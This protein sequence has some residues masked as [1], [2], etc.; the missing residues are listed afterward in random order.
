MHRRNGCP[1]VTNERGSE[2]REGLRAV[3]MRAIVT[4]AGPLSCEMGA[5]R[6]AMDS[7]GKQ[8]SHKY[9]V[10]M[11]QSYEKA[12]NVVQEDEER[13]KQDMERKR[14]AQY[15][16]RSGVFIPARYRQQVTVRFTIERDGQK[17]EREISGLHTFDIGDRASREL[18]GGESGAALLDRET[19]SVLL[20]F[21]PDQ[22]Q[23]PL[24]RKTTKMN[25]N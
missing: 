23:N 11:A 21:E 17:E 1:S 10:Y 25:G 13:A 22:W 16:E 24:L 15:Q 20:G 4:E 2:D 8:P 12:E 6:Y 5:E 9:A 14:M 19:Q 3:K 18:H 7:D